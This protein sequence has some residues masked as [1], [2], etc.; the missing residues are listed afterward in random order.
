[1]IRKLLVLAGTLCVG[2]FTTTYAQPVA[3]EHIAYTSNI[4]GDDE[5]FI[6]P[7][8]GGQPRNLTQ[9]GA[10]DWHPAWSPD[11]SQLTF[12][13]NRDGSTDIFLMNNTGAGVLNLTNTPTINELAPA[14]SPDGTRIVFQANNGDGIDLYT[15]DVNN[16]DIVQITNDGAD[17][18]N[19]AWSP[20]STQVAYF[21]NLGQST[22][23]RTVDVESGVFTTIVDEGLN[24]Y[25][26][27]S[28]DGST[29]A[30]FRLIEGLP[31][32]FAVDVASGVVQQV[33]QGETNDLQPTYSPGGDALVFASQRNGT[34]G[35]FAMNSDGSNVV[36]IVENGANN[37]FPAWQPVPAVIEDLNGVGATVQNFTVVR[38]DSINEND[39][40][41][42]GEI[43]LYAPQQVA[44]DDVIIVRVEIAADA[45]VEKFTTQVATTETPENAPTALPLRETSAIQLRQYM[46]ARLGG[47][48]FNKFEVYPNPTNYVIELKPDAVNYWEWMLI[49]RTDVDVIG[50]QRLIVEIYVP[51]RNEDGILVE[52]VVKNSL[53]EVEVMPSD[54]PEVADLDLTTEF[55]IETASE[56][57]AIYGI[58]VNLVDDD[59]VTIV[60]RQP[61]QVADL[62]FHSEFAAWDFTHLEDLELLNY[63]LNRGDCVRLFAEGGD[64]SPLP[65][66]CNRDRTFVATLSA[67]DVFWYDFVAGTPASVIIQEQPDG[68]V[69]ACEAEQRV[70]N[71]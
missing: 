65:N 57:A 37:T 11:G 15:I 30:F 14:W 69:A 40:L 52:T 55:N 58:A 41:N 42:E 6:I 68:V 31:R 64:G 39:E 13:S 61:A 16:G 60:F 62:S 43:R 21:Q 59:N 47:L 50:K 8:D 4:E 54:A 20:N 12:A 56:Q 49:P 24:T 46:G 34:L 28:P 26:A 2:A 5:I 9:N 63:E 51:Q 1:M 32:I 38:A 10:R 27:W 23:I 53:F 48:G 19:A 36:T 71:F 45:L 70:C 33:T 18:G 3:K 22:E 66:L 17:K 67:F 7:V 35:I 25:P 29:I 44:V